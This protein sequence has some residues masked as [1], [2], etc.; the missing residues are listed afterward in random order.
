MGWGKRYYTPG[1]PTTKN[2]VKYRIKT[3]FINVVPKDVYD[4]DFWR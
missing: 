4:K 2:F 1:I 3:Y